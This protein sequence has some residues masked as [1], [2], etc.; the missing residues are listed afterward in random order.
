M[1]KHCEIHGEFEAKTLCFQGQQIII[2]HCPACKIEAQKKEE[3]DLA[4]AKKQE[5]NAH[6]NKLIE[7]SNIPKRFLLKTFDDFKTK[8]NAQAH[9]LNISKN[10]ALDFEKHFFAGRCLIFQGKIGTGKSH[11]ASNIAFSIIKAQMKHVLWTSAYDML[12]N[13][14]RAWKSKTLDEQDIILKYTKPDVL[15]I[16]EVGLNYESD[17]DHLLL[18]SIINKRYEEILPTIILTNLQTQD[19]IRVIGDRS[20]DRLR[21]NAGVLVEFNWESSRI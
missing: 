7:I 10:Y 2:E 6:F 19:L 3:A 11:L 15:I 1:L 13:I 5:E 4:L 17:S 9:A 8:T 12:S 20:F 16:D 18:S 14:K 21:E